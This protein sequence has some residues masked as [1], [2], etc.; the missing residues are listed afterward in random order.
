MATPPLREWIMPVVVIAGMLGNIG[1]QVWSSSTDSHVTAA[2]VAVLTARAAELSRT[3]QVLSDKLSEMP[4]PDEIAANKAHLDRIDAAFGQIA[5]RFG[6]VE[7]SA[8]AVDAR[9]GF[10]ERRTRP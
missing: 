3:L 7:A 1:V 9:V 6:R 8:A 10:I 5:D 4:R 2:Q